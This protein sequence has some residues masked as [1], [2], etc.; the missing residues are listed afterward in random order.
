MEK[1]LAGQRHRHSEVIEEH[2]YNIPIYSIKL[3]CYIFRS[4]EL[5][6][7]DLFEDLEVKYGRVLVSHAVGYKIVFF[8]S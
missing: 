4:I 1:L 2:E 7:S 6:I 3:K 5:S 8:T